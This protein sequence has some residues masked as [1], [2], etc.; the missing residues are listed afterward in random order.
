ME[1]IINHEQRLYVQRSEAG[2]SCLGFD[3]VERKIAAVAAWAGLEVQP[4]EPGTV[5]AYDEYLRIMALGAHHSG[6]TRLRCEAELDPQLVGLEGKIVEVVDN[7]GETRRFRVG[8]S[9]GWMPIHLEIE[10]G[11]PTGGPGA[12]GPYKSVRAVKGWR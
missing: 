2:Y 7:E 10:R 9:T 3:V 12:M 5:G 4:H 6:V 1:L 11:D 8:K